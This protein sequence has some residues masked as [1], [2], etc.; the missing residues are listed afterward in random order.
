MLIGSSLAFAGMAVLAKLAARQ[1]PGYEVAFVRFAVGCACCFAVSRRRPFRAVNKRGLVQRGMLGGLAVLGYFLAIEHLPVGIA[2]LLNYSAPVF[3]ALWAALLFGEPL[4]ARAAVA[5]AI[6]TAGVYFVV[7]GGQVG[8]ASVGLWEIV[9][10]A[11]AV[12]SGA[13][14]ATIREVRR[15]DGAWEIFAAFCVAGLAITAGPTLAHWRRPDAAE[16][17]LLVL[18]GATSVA[19]QLAM[20][21]SLR[22]LRAVEAGIISQLTPVGALAIGALFLGERIGGVALVGAAL[23]LTGVVWGALRAGPAPAPAVEDP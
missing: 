6:T 15:T 22:Y 4:K 10:A 14:V 5:L 17:A 1:V 3:T 23:V 7:R 20:T 19:A 2:T 12:L 9:G 16:W 8:S 18:V 21:W 11:S 13:A